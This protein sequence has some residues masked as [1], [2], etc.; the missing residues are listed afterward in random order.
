MSSVGNEHLFPPTATHPTAST[1]PVFL[2]LINS[3]T[4]EYVDSPDFL[5]VRCPN[6]EAASRMAKMIGEY[7]DRKDSIGGT[8]TCVIRN[9]P[10]GLGE[11]WYVIQIASNPFSI[12]LG[13][14]QPLVSIQI[15]MECHSLESHIGSH[16]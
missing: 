16:Y 8:V 6:K 10:V 11:P 7:R 13:A 9:P 5:P 12:P 4:R 14:T 15:F 2:D 3:I 1:N